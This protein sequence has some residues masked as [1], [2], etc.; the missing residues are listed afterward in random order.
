MMHAPIRATPIRLGL[1]GC[2]RLA[3]LGYV[4]ALGRTD[5]VQ[6]VA[7]ADPDHARA[8]LVAGLAARTGDAVAAFTDATA[9]VEGAE[10]D[11]VVVASPAGA[12]VADASV[13][14]AAG[15]TV[16][17]EKPPAPAAEGARSLAALARA[18]WLGFNRRFDPGVRALRDAVPSAGELDM[19]LE[20]QYRRASWRA[21]SV[22]DDALLDLGPH[23]VDWARWISSSEI[24]AVAAAE[25][26]Q[27]RAELSVTLERGRA[28]VV[29]SC[30]RSHR[31]IA[32]VRDES[33]GMI[34]RHVVGGPVAAV[35]G[36]L[37]PGPHPLVSSLSREL[38][39]LARVMRGGGPGALGTADDGVAIMAVIDGARASAAAGGRS[40][41]VERSGA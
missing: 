15:V 14:T 16:L 35:L 9:L 5:A 13:A 4:P 25:I 34:G 18:P 7:V 22:H 28:R 3:E 19:N 31:E 20:I 10:L 41:S 36:R 38:E 2:G 37:R 29:A 40:V 33:G 27:D 26:S 21:H 39:E 32:E 23:L 24:T 17:V 1:V 6:L 30:D 12:H 11:A 8:E